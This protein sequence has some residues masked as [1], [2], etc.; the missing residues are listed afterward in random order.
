MMVAADATLASPMAAGGVPLVIS[1]FDTA[2]P[3]GPALGDEERTTWCDF[4][5]VFEWRREG[6]KDGCNFVPARFKLEEDGRHVR[7]LKANVLAR[8]AIA[9][10]IEKNKKTGQVPP[11]LDD[12]IRPRRRPGIGVPWLHLTH[13]P[14][15]RYSIPPGYAAVG[16]DRTRTACSGRAWPNNPA[17]IGVLDHSKIGP[18]SLFYLPSCP[19]DALGHHQTTVIPGAPIDAAW[20]TEMAGALLAARQAEARSHRGRSTGAG[21]CSQRGEAGR[22]LRPE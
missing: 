6:E 15:R 21:C 7:R 22:G 8:T 11:I 1:W 14:W 16:G 2:R 20:V 5:S 18:A 17:L 13:S 4:A 3:M 9:L 12:V 19:Y 10:D